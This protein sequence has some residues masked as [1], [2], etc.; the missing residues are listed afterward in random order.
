MEREEALTPVEIERIGS[1]MG[2]E[3]GFIQQAIRQLETAVRPWPKLSAKR[4]DLWMKAAAFVIPVLWGLLTLLASAHGWTVWTTLFGVISL[5]PLAILLSMLAG[6]KDLA[7][8][9]LLSLLFAVAPA[10]F[11][12][13]FIIAPVGLSFSKLLIAGGL[14][15]RREFF[16][17]ESAPEKP[18]ISRQQLV[19][20]LFKLQGQLEGQKQRRIFLSVDVVGSSAMSQSASDLVVEHA[21]SQFRT[22]LEEIIQSEGGVVQSVAGDGSMCMFSEEVSAVRAARRLQSGLSEFNVTR[23]RLAQPFRL[24]CGICSGEVALEE[25]VPLRE[26]Q[27]PA[28]YRAAMLQK[29]AEPGG[30]VVGEEVVIV[31]T[32]ELSGLTPLANPP[33]DQAAYAWRSSQTTLNS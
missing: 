3:P 2:V 15:L 13:C 16:P 18:P 9:A 6:K 19:D 33:S 5:P 29:R 17:S 4:A 31:A 21:F 25:G 10:T 22:W 20:L 11:P 1:E 23:N 12:Y 8:Y 30:I 24:R 26:I 14:A 28:M 7:F 27:S 32:G